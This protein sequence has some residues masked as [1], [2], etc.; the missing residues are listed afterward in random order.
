MKGK[1]VERQRKQSKGWKGR[2]ATGK[3]REKRRGGKARKLVRYCGGRVSQRRE[4][5]RDAAGKR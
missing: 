1:G 3:K 5:E 2:D 4:E